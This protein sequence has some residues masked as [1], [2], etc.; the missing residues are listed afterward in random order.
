MQSTT[1]ML[2]LATVVGGSVALLLTGVTTAMALPSAAAA[3]GETLNVTSSEINHADDESPGHDWYRLIYNQSGVGSVAR[4]VVDDSE[5]VHHDGAL[6][7][8]TPYSDGRLDIRYAVDTRATDALTLADLTGARV[9]VKVTSPPA[10]VFTVEFNCDGHS[11]AY[12]AGDQVAAYAGAVPSDGQ[13]HTIDVGGD[14][15]LWMVAGQLQTRA[16]LISACP[17]NV[18]SNYGFLQSGAGAD[19][20]VD[21]VSVGGLTTN[22]WVSPLERLAGADRRETACALATYSFSSLEDLTFYPP[23][24]GPNPSRAPVE[25]KAVVLVSDDQ[26]ADALSAGPLAALVDAPLLLNHGDT[27]RTTCD[28]M[29]L[30]DGGTVY[31]VGGAGV[32]SPALESAIQSRGLTTVRLGGQDRYQTAVKVAQEIDTLRPVGTPQQVFLASGTDFPD[33]LSAGAP[34]GHSS[35][36]VLLTR[37]RHMTP[38]TAAYLAER[39]DATVFAIGGPAAEAAT[40]P[41]SNELVGAN[42]YET[43]TIVADRFFPEPTTAAFASGANYPD[44][45]SAAAYGGNVAAPVLLMAPT[46]VPDVVAAYVQ[47]HRGTLRGSVLL[48]GTGAVSDA[49]FTN[50]LTALAPPD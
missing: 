8:S 24:Y 40:L 9:A 13:W 38:A 11:D 37:G 25:A 30:S 43:A 50:L 3:D 12:P 36:A 4:V 5:P 27:V 23:S 47:R 49:T 33:A 2:Q 10:P 42:R 45:L 20:L 32:L 41:A 35:G 21:D 39:P 7:L 44:A 17:Q 29:T 14:G 1:K 15:A 18:L 19:A 26:Y 46:A 34:A 16:Q 48:G 31:L 28:L 6:R 22:F